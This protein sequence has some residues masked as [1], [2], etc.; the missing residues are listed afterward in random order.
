M[1]VYRNWDKYLNNSIQLNSVEL[2]GRGRRFSEPKY[3]NMEEAINDVY[4]T[5]S[6]LIRDSDYAVFG[7]SMGS[8]I[9][10]E[11]IHRLKKEGLHN[12]EHVFFSGLHPPFEKKKKP[13]FHDAPLEVLIDEIRNLGGTPEELLKNDD[14]IETFIPIIRADYKILE[15]YDCVHKN[16]KFEF[17]I[18]VLSGKQDN[19]LNDNYLEAWK[20]CTLG[21]CSIYKFD[22]GH[23]FINEKAEDTVKLINKVLLSYDF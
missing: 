16:T 15:T 12:P 6:P 13:N 18:S 1:Q 8:V 11:L 7:H 4:N 2:S 10:Y 5:V 22:G 20:N 14:F 23:F 9:V 17:D 19:D 3:E 21:K